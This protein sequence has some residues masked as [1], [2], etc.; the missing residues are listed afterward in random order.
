MWKETLQDL[1]RAIGSRPAIM[2]SYNFLEH[3]DQIAREE[4]VAVARSQ[5]IPT[6]FDTVAD[7]PPPDRVWH[8][9]HMRYG[10]VAFS[11]GKAIHGPQDVGLLFGRSDLIEAARLNRVP[12]AGNVG[13]GM[14]DS[15]K[16]I[17]A[18]WV[19]V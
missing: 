19:A 11:S 10:L 17:I 7:T 5:G 18:M 3:A 4:W 12:H 8:P 1:E 13:R 2:F 9:N 15:K 16:D 6:L 14:K